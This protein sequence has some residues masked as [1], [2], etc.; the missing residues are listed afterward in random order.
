MAKAQDSASLALMKK[1]D[2]VCD[3]F[4]GDW[5]AGKK[6]VIEK[7]LG[8]TA[9]KERAELLRALLRLELELRA[10]GGKGANQAAYDKR[11]PDDAD[12]VQS[13][14]R[15]L[16]QR[17]TMNRASGA[18]DTSV[19]AAA[20]TS[21]TSEEMPER[22][23]RFQI[24]SVLGQGAFG[25]VYKAHDPDLERDVA[26]KVPLKSA[27]DS[28]EELERFQREAKAAATLHHPNLCPVY[29]VG[30]TDGGPYI[31]MA[32]IDGK[33]LSTVL[34]ERKEP[35]AA[36]QAALIVRKLA[37]A[38]DAAHAKGI[39]HRDL[40]P[41]NVIIDRDRK[42]VIIMDFG[43]A[44]HRKKG[45]S[46]ETREG[47]VMGTPAYMSPEQARGDM[48]AIGPASD[49]YSLGIIL[50][51]ML[52]GRPPFSGTVTEVLG[53]VMHV[54]PDAPRA[55]RDGVDPA[56]EAICLTAIAKTPKERYSSMKALA[57]ELDNYLKGVPSESITTKPKKKKASDE[58]GLTQV[59]DA[60]SQERKRDRDAMEK[61]VG[62]HSRVLLFVI[63]AAFGALGCMIAVSGVIMFFFR[64]PNT[65]VQITLVTK[66]GIDPAQMAEE[67]IA[68]YLNNNLLTVDELKRPIELKL[69]EHTLIAKRDG[70]EVQRWVF[71]VAQSADGNDASIQIKQKTDYVPKVVDKGKDKDDGWAPLFDDQRFKSDWEG[72]PGY[73]QFKD[74][75]LVGSSKGIKHNTY[76]V[77]KKPYGDFELKFQARLTGTNPNSGVQIRSMTLDPAKFTVKGPQVD[78]GDK[79]WGG[80]YG[81]QFGGWMK[82]P[83]AGVVAKAVKA[84][85]FNDYHVKVIGKH[86][87]ITLNG[88]VTV[89]GDFPT[90]PDQG[91]LAWQIHSGPPMDVVFRN[92][93]I[94]EP[95][96]GWTPLFNGRDLSGWSPGRAG[97]WKIADGAITASGPLDFLYS[98][99]DDFGDFHLR[100]EVKINANGNSGIYFRAN[101]PAVLVGDYEAQITNEAGQPQKTGS[102]YGLAIVKDILVPA[103]TWFTYE[104]IANGSN[105]RLFVNGKQTAEYEEKRPGRRSKGHIALQHH[106]PQ[107]QVHYRKIEIKETRPANEGFAS[108]FNGKDLTGWKVDGSPEHFK[109]EQG[110]I[111]AIPGKGR[112]WLFSDREFD[113]FDLKLKF[114]VAPGANGGVSPRGVPGDGGGNRLQLE[115]QVRDDKAAKQAIT[116]AIVFS[117]I[118]AIEPQKPASLR[119]AGEWN[120]MLIEARGPNIKV[121]VNGQLIQDADLSKFKLDQIKGDKDWGPKN[122]ARRRG[123]VGLQFA[124][125]AEVRYRDIQV[126]EAKSVA[127]VPPV[128]ADPERAAAEWALQHGGAV[129]L[130]LDGNAVVEVKK[131]GDLP[132]RPFRVRHLNLFARKGV[133]SQGVANLRGLKAIEHL[134]LGNTQVDD[135]GLEYLK[136]LTPLKFLNL[137]GLGISD[138]GLAHL[139]NLTAL[140]NLNLNG[141]RITAKGMSY[142]QAMTRLEGLAIRDAAI[143]DDSLIALK[144]MR[145]LKYFDLFHTS[146]SGAGLVHLHGLPITHLLLGDGTP[147]TDAG[148]QSVR[149]FKK[150]ASLH[151]GHTQIGNAGLAHLKGMTIETLILDGTKIT[152]DGLAALKD[153]NGLKEVSLHRMPLTNTA[154]PHLKALTGLAELHLDGTQV[155]DDGLAELQKA[156]PKCKITPR[157]RPVEA[158]G[159]R[160]IFNGKDLSG[161]VNEAG[162]NAFKLENDALVLLPGPNPRGYLYSEKEYADFELKLEFKLEANATSAI[163]IRGALGEIGGGKQLKI[164][165]RDQP[166]GEVRST[167]SLIL[168]TKNVVPPQHDV[169]MRPTGEWN[170]IHVEARGSVIKVAV[171]NMPALEQDLSALVDKSKNEA[172]IFL[173]NTRRRVGRIG[174]Q[175]PANSAVFFRNVFVRELKSSK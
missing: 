111:V 97:A 12:V 14:F 85:D 59:A 28:A 8:T 34:K 161:W 144:N 166:K 136:D 163:A 142:L 118:D 33:T 37:L 156:L 86:V 69:G 17:A 128:N 121:T 92:I 30:Q 150:L 82:E 26:I 31:V 98:E 60:L 152:D 68:Y 131:A 132:A 147:L 120:D 164:I 77:S 79:Y 41:S 64:G 151:V 158:D 94:R 52:A 162:P 57:D 99:R 1:I 20:T 61:A 88:V 16:S 62:K 114:K 135:Q 50:Y 146:I 67:K 153:V 165:L 71:V 23:G 66:L 160:R 110:D 105:I 19:D 2:A 36:K 124:S 81:E 4:E 109:V 106:D 5:K 155:S 74:G 126:R 21:A 171:N 15:E 75:D 22:I 107:T 48:K 157:P 78:M 127:K 70:V 159:S 174:L 148:L 103:D 116:G 87:T 13:V 38:L 130:A 32:L 83:D 7:Y 10:A 123:R 27:F 104:V 108:L 53:K 51:E 58:P 80:L 25:R 102:L 100:A 115:I 113:D 91:V 65:V 149:G 43:L 9:G 134:E 63:L 129:S 45:D 112:S 3:R 143:T 46:K 76:L 35:L 72:L 122:L 139:K 29:E 117:G 101:K 44:R 138:V 11:F 167:G 73:W 39:L 95:S 172:D 90:M 56:L 49:I 89:D 119:P 47:V 154:L 42:D 141:N 54:E 24:L 140:E 6:P 137:Q 175:V 168:S 170:T 93:R 169:T 173:K 96:D 40:K 55:H 145:G 84:N 133:T 18:A 125:A